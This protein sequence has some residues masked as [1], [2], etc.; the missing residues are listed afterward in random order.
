MKLASVLVEIEHLEKEVH[1]SQSKVASMTK[2]VETLNVHQKL[3]AEALGKANKKML[4]SWTLEY[5]A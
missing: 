4:G 5:Q 1:L 3:A 2:R